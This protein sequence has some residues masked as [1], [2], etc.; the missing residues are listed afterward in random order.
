M[1]YTVSSGT[2]NSTIGLP[3]HTNPTVSP[4]VRHTE[5]LLPYYFVKVYCSRVLLCIRYPLSQDNLFNARRR[6]FG[7]YFLCLLIFGVCC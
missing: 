1:T 2:L 7:G 6:V 3:Y 4:F 5:N